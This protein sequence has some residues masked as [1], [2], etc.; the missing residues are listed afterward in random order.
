MIEAKARLQLM[1]RDIKTINNGITYGSMEA[2]K[3]EER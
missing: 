1:V 2:S 3:T